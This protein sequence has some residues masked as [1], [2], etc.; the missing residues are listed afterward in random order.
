MRK[1][2]T[3][4]G[5]LLAISAASYSQPGSAAETA[6]ADES[7]SS[8]LEEVMVTAQ[9]RV[10]PSQD[11]PI[12][13]T[14]FTTEDM[15]IADINTA[16]DY[17]SMAPNVSFAEDG[18][19]GQNSIRISIRGVSN[20]SLGERAVANSIGYYIDEFNVGTVAAGT[21][22]PTLLDMATVE[23]LRG[24]QGTY[25]GR[26]AAGGAINISTN[27]P[28]KNWFAEVSGFGGNYDTWGGHLIVNTP[29]S[30]TF[31]LRG[32]IGF[33][34]SNGIVKNVNPLGTPNSG[35]DHTDARLAARWLITPQFTADAS[36]TYA[37]YADGID[38][39]VN[40]G[41]LELDTISIEG[42]T[43]RPI[44]D[45]L[46]FYPRNQSLVNHGTH[47][48]WNDS[49]LHEGNLRLAYDFG[50]AT[51]KSITGY[52]ETTNNR[53][54]DEDGVS[55]DAINRS[56]QWEAKSYGEELRLQSKPS[57]TLDW[58]VGAIY[59][60][61]TVNNHSLVALGTQFTYTYPDTGVTVPVIPP[62]PNLP[63]NENVASY[64]DKN[65]GVYA[66]ATW[67]P[68]PKWALTLGG[69]Y[70][71]D[72]IDD[73]VT[74][75]VAFGTP[76][77]DLYGSS[78]YNDFSPRVVVSYK[79]T[80][81]N[82]L[83]GTVSHGYKA[84]GNDLN[85]ELPEQNKPFAP[86][87]VWNYEVGYKSEFLDHKA[88]FNASMFYLDWH[89]LQSEV[90]YLAVPGD[91]SS[92]VQVTE[93]ASSA[94]SKGVEV[95]T[96][97]R[98]ITPLTLALSAGYLDAKFGSFP[99]AV[100]YGMPVDMSGLPLPQ[101]PKWTGSATVQWTQTFGQDSS[102]Y[103]RWDE[104]YRDSSF[105]NL[106]AV[107][108]ERLGL[109]SFPFQMPS[110]AVANFNAGVNVGRFTLAGTVDNAFQKE[111]YTG[112]GDHFGFGGVRVRPHP[113]MWRLQLTYRTH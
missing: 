93:N 113:R 86:E 22:N 58:V 74:G 31:F 33:E 50:G 71:H 54:Y 67:K 51:L 75:L 55:V 91:I 41:V 40:T 64:S 95:E 17:L 11:V 80:S 21:I 82:M 103:V 59:A 112:T 60:K 98:P 42:P 26:N 109:P 78:S 6:T 84:G 56:N 18:L 89:D 34:S 15:R 32:V 106:E 107:G 25:F 44:D 69:R 35:Y 10:E 92:A 27:L 38:P 105:S 53:F 36:F 81:D 24:P 62:F 100:I 47:R 52:I 68:T 96:R 8:Q 76:Q 65:S 101:S 3:F 43:F 97:F 108:A 23:V 57:D 99:T 9:R 28:D 12:S 14:A 79:P 20:V 61:D 19:N 1:F 111:Y 29:V 66:E 88:L 46:G 90:N 49:D 102:W 7:S 94:T 5:G 48:E 87:K 4:A 45:G 72:Q 2:T 16:A 83:Y 30:D 110:Y 70:S 77:A 85:A 37:H 63:V 104:M 73:S 13:L 39:N